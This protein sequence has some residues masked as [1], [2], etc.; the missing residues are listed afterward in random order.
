[1]Q[2]LRA[3]KNKYGE[4]RVL[5][6]AT[7]STEGSRSALLSAAR[8]M[9]IDVDEANYLT[10]LIP[11]ERGSNWSLSDCYFGNGEGRKPVTELI[12]EVNKH[13]GLMEI[14]LKIE[15]LIKNNSVHASGI[16][17]FND[18]YTK[19]NAMMK[20][21]TG[22]ETTQFDMEDSDYMGGL[23]IDALT[24]SN[25]DKIRATMEMLIEDGYMEWQGSLR[26]TYN[27]Y[28]HPKVL[29]YD[30]TEMWKKVQNND[31]P[32]LFQFDT[33]TGLQTA[34]KIKPTNVREL[35]AANNL[36]RLMPD[37]GMMPVDK[38]VLHKQNPEAWDKEMDE[39]GLTETEKNIMKEHLGEKLGVADAQEDIMLLSMDERI[40][41]FSVVEANNL[42]KAVARKKPEILEEVKKQFYNKGLKIASK[43]L[44]DYV[45]N[46][47]IMPQAGY[48]FSQ[49]H[50]SSYSLIA[51]QNMNLAHRYPQVYWNTACLT[52]NSGANEESESDKTSQYGKVGIAISDMQQ[53]GIV[54]VPPDINNSNF[55][56]KPDA[57][58]NTIIFG[59]KGVHGIGDDIVKTIIENRPYQ[60][61]NDFLKRMIDTKLVKN[62]QMLQLIKAGSFDSFDSRMNIMK[63]YIN[64]IFQ[65]R[66]KLSLQ[67]FNIVNELGVIPSAYELQIRFYKFRNYISKFVYGKAKNRTTKNR[68]FLLNDIST[69]FFYEHFSENCIVDYHENYPIIAEWSFDKE[70]EKLIKPLKDWF[71]KK[72]TVDLVNSKLL[73]KEWE[74]KAQ[75][76]IKEWEMSALTYYYSGHEL[77]HLN[78]E[79]Y[80]VKNFN[81]LPQ[82]P[83]SVRE[84]KWNGRDMHEYQLCRIA[85][86]VLDKNKDKS[87]IA[88]LTPNG[89]VNVKYYRGAYGHY[90]KQISQLNPDGTKTVVEKSWFARG[91]KL[92]ITGFRRGNQFI[93]CTYRNSVYQHSTQLINSID[94]DGNLSLTSERAYA[95]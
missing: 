21:S 47:Q 91:T 76:S 6:I 16:Y 1:M 44:L 56:F 63:Q 37:S 83:V 19:Q 26:D 28:L 34:Q 85:G 12:N 36:M 94:E 31:I 22:L 5:N 89:V 92:L 93:P 35:G 57:K 33:S 42:R 52:I 41:N 8:G 7:F 90:D 70:Y 20:S 95:D 87:T 49:L 72:S 9:G 55:G 82:N 84:Y 59:L 66:T 58:N 15:N 40:S 4:D 48:G 13:E 65:P 32:D 77:E 86:T 67:S 17:I 71:A 27:K 80:D 69:K 79:K 54:V 24:V 11:S 23:K 14:S 61:F 73:E 51:L 18:R 45:W 46:T 88:L 3:L 30:D 29:K 74:T 60:S 75:G 50:S 53:R 2:I 25:M 78:N 39:Y 43:N 81:E 62:S 10:S 64:H 38:Y 68:L